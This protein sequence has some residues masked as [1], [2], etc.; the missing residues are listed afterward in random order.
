MVKI[1]AKNPNYDP[2]KSNVLQESKVFHESPVNPRKCADILAN[3]LYM[4][5]KG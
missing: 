3:I 5:N 4:I 2:E 1:D